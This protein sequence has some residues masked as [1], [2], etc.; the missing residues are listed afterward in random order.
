[1][2]II[3]TA[4][5]REESYSETLIYSTEISRS[6]SGSED[7][8]V[9]TRFNGTEP[10][11]RIAMS[12]YGYSR[13]ETAKLLNLLIAAARNS[14]DG[15]WVPLW[16]SESALTVAAAGGSGSIAM[17]DTAIGEYVAGGFFVLIDSTDPTHVQLFTIDTIA[18]GTSITM[19]TTVTTAFPLGSAVVPVVFCAPLLPQQVGF[20]ELARIMA[21]VIEFEEVA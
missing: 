8:R 12:P 5:P 16:W 7:G 13:E 21:G 19:T 10:V 15:L 6:L 18:S 1:M 17:A 9:F 14:D 3:F 2:A 20:D 4:R 11:H